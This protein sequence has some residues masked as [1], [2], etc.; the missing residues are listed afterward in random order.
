MGRCRSKQ[1]VARHC[2]AF[3]QDDVSAGG[4]FGAGRAP[5]DAFH[6]RVIFEINAGQHTICLR[7]RHQQKTIA[8]RRRAL[9]RTRESDVEG[10]RFLSPPTVPTR[11][12]S[13]L[14]PRGPA[15]CT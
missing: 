13:F 9:Q 4:F 1:S 10:F 7:E 3:S 5:V 8:Q 12:C 15:S 14:P 2:V 6:Q 11:T